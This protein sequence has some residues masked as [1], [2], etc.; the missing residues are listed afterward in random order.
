MTKI[1]VAVDGRDIIGWKDLAKLGIVLRPG[2]DNPISLG[3][4]PIVVSEISV[5]VTNI[6][7]SFTKK[8]PEVFADVI[9][10][11]K[12]FEHCIKLKDG[13]VPVSHKKR[14]YD[15][16]KNVSEVMVNVNDWVLI[17]KPC[18]VSKGAS[19]YSLPVKV[20]RVTK[21]AVLLEGKGWWNKNSIIPISSSQADIFKQV[22]AGREDEEDASSSAAFIDS[23][24]NDKM[25]NH[26]LNDS[27]CQ[28]RTSCHSLEREDGPAV[29]S[30]SVLCPVPEILR[31]RS[32]RLVKLPSKYNDYLLK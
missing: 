17:K 16:R 14:N 7:E 12:G 28:A 22:Y 29:S 5:P 31:T 4:M 11:V 23:S 20:V 19:R 21:S 24:T 15:S 10:V 30:S 8:Y 32:H 1:Y 13:A 26:A 18:R 9:G 27:N 3:E 25:S 6:S 2:F